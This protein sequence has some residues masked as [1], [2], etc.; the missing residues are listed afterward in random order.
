MF[1]YFTLGSLFD[2]D[3]LFQSFF[4][5]FFYFGLKEAFFFL[6]SFFLSFLGGVY[7]TLSID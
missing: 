7:P 2:H 3:C 6:L 1:D 4:F 5:I